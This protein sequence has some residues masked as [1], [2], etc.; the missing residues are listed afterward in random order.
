[1]AIGAIVALLLTRVLESLLFGVAAVHVPTFAITAAAMIAIALVAS[2]LPA[3]RASTI[4]PVQ[5]LRAE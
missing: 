2:Y 3:R 1:M 5:A 4:D